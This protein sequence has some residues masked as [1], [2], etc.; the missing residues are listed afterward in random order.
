MIQIS[1]LPD[2][3]A[4]VAGQAELSPSPATTDAPV[5]SLAWHLSVAWSPA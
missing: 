1:S 3:A 5:S 2:H 4:F